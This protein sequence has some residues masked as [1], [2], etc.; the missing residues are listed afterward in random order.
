[1]SLKI[2][3]VINKPLK[4][5]ANSG[6]M[7]K[8]CKNYRAD[9]AKFITGLSVGSILAKDGYGCYIYVKQ[10][11]KNKQIPKEKR[12]FLSAL[13]LATGALM[14]GVQVLSYLAVTKN[15]LPQ[16]AFGAMFNK[17]FSADNAQKIQQKC[18]GKFQDLKP[19]EFEKTFV[20][21]KDDIS[22]AFS[23]LTTLLGVTILAKRVL[24]PF[25]ATP[26][27]D[28]LKEAHFLKSPTDEK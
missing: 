12:D 10:N 25:I 13:D 20:Q 28:K 15:K 21:Y 23:H 4:K 6:F 17:Y 24:V 8:I 14:I 11:Q 2:S 7:E 27:S 26:V 5:L 1:M 3:A 18:A 22:L 19:D 16:K 9:N